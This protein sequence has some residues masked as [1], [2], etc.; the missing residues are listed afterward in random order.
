MNDSLPGPK[1]IVMSSNLMLF[2]LADSS[3]LLAGP[4]WSSRNTRNAALA[5]GP[6][7]ICKSLTDCDTQ[8]RQIYK[9]A[10]MQ[11]IWSVYR[12]DH[13]SRQ[14]DR[15]FLWNCTHCWLSAQGTGRYLGRSF[16]WLGCFWWG[17]SQS[18]PSCSPRRIGWQRNW[19]WTVHLQDMQVWNEIWATYAICYAAW[20]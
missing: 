6:L 4:F 11:T 18:Y 10:W 5:V 2:C 15:A 1:C 20:V 12:S 13:L 16:A 19:H 14:S 7:L 8:L 9:I 3:P 17:K